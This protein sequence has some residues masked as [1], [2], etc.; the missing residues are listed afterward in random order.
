MARLP[1]GAL[2]QRAAAGLAAAVHRPAGRGYGR[3]VLLLVG[4]GRQR[5]RRAVRRRDARPPRGARSRRCCCRTAPTRRAGRAPRGRGSRRRAGRR[6]AARR[7]GG[8]DRRDRRAA[9]AAAPARDAALALSPASR[10]SRSTC[11]RGVDVDTGELDG[12]HV[13]ADVTVTFGTHKVGHLVDPAARPPASSS[14]STS[15]SDL[16]RAAV[17]ALQ[18]DDVAALL[19]RPDAYAQKYTRG[20][21]GVRAG[22]ERYPGAGVLCRRGALRAGRDGPVRRAGADAVRP[23]TPRSSSARAG[24]GLGGRFRRRRRRRRRRRPSGKV[25]VPR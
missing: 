2:M 17:E 25:Q 6:A 19:P 22:S 12:P 10:S 13:T 11:R 23:R 4:V 8:R 16:A 20:V 5:R 9:R 1:E 3:R 24:A 21:V 14:S 18:A 7:G 15:G